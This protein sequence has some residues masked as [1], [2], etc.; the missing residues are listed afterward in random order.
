MRRICMYRYNSP[1]TFSRRLITLVIDFLVFMMLTLFGYILCEQVNVVL[2]NTKTNVITGEARAIQ[3]ELVSLL[4]EAHLGYM[5]DGNICDTGDMAENYVTTLYRFSLDELHEEYKEPLYHYYGNYKEMQANNFVGDLGN[6]GEQYIYNRI[7]QEVDNENKQYYVEQ[8][9]WAYPI[10]R[11]EVATALKEW[12]ENKQETTTIDEV[13]Y[14]GAKI[15]EDIVRVYKLLLQEAR[16]ELCSGYEGYAEKYQSLNNLRNELVG[17]KITQLIL[18]YLVITIIW[19]IVFPVFLKNGA[20]LSNKIFKMGACT[21]NGE[22]IPFWSIVL[23]WGMKTLKYFN[24]IY[25][26]LILLYSIN[27][28]TFMDY[29]VLGNVKFSVF[30]FISG[31]FMISSVVCCAVDKKKYRTFSDFISM[32][33]MKDLRD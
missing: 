21:K 24:V 1:V 22:N 11:K 32:Q 8:D 14:N 19:Y 6:V 33:E 17:C 16:Y 23:K 12:L 2:P 4:E 7:L 15:A 28:K 31:G 29:R 9:S 10:L 30:Y 18:V 20:S 26:V 13:S 27:S 25:F 5:V 3:K